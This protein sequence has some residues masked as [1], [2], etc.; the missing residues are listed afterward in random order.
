[1]KPPEQ[2]KRE[3]VRQWVCKANKDLDAAR[4][5]LQSGPSMGGIVGFHAQQAAEKYVKAYLTWNQID[6]PKTH[7]I[8][9]L[10]VLISGHNEELAERLKPAI[11]LSSYAVEARYPADIPDISNCEAEDALNLAERTRGLI[12]ATLK[13]FLTVE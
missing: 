13:S 8:G 6:F 2:I 10:I 3:L 5:L 11:L 9:A 1:M 7:N 4:I 12:L